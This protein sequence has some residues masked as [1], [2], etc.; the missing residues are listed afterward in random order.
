MTDLK[1]FVLNNEYPSYQWSDDKGKIHFFYTSQSKCIVYDVLQ[2]SNGQNTLHYKYAYFIQIND[3]PSNALQIVNDNTQVTSNN[4]QPYTN[5]VENIQINN[6]TLSILQVLEGLKLSLNNEINKNVLLVS[7]IEN[8]H[9]QYLILQKEATSLTNT[10]ANLSSQLNMKDKI[11][12]KL[13]REN[14]NLK[15]Q[16]KTFRSQKN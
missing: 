6:Q 8:V 11:I 12:C 2:D 4:T 1:N 7:N 15:S 3:I 14:A 5:S 13:T 9:S 10:I 16:L